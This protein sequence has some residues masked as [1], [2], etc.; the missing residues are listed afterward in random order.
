MTG[1]FMKKIVSNLAIVL[2]AS[3]LILIAFN[4]T[5]SKAAGN[6]FSNV[7]PFV[8]N[9]GLIGFFDQN[10]GMIYLYD[11]DLKNCV[12]SVQLTKLGDPSSIIKPFIPPQQESIKYYKK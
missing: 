4:Q 8:N 5:S 2:T 12:L 3:L 10:D 11:G 9:T 6:S 1:G 7:V